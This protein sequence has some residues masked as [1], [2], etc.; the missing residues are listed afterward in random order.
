MTDGF[1]RP[2]ALAIGAVYDGDADPELFPS[3]YR[4]AES[5]ARAAMEVMSNMTGD[6]RAIRPA[7]QHCGRVHTTTCPRIAAIDYDASG[8]IRRVEFHPPAHSGNRLKGKMVNGCFVPE[9]E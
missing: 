3:N 8:Q 6:M 4:R 7:C 2:L 1:L 9:V 5:A